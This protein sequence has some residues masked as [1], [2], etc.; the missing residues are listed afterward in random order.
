[1]N[2]AS[3]WSASTSCGLRFVAWK[4]VEAGV[5]GPATRCDGIGKW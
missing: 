2:V 4:C 1:M 3:Q 5:I